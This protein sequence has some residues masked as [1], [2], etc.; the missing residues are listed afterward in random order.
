MLSKPKEIL[1]VWAVPC[2]LAFLASAGVMA[3]EMVAG[4]MLARYVGGS[5]YLWTSVIGVILGGMTVGNFIGG[6]L[7][8]RFDTRKTVPALFLL[9]A[10]VCFAIPFMNEWTILWSRWNVVNEVSSWPWR[11]F[12]HVFLV[13]FLPAVCLGLVSPVVAKRALEQ[14][15]ATGRTVGNVY[16]CGALGSIVGTFVTGFVLIDAVGTAGVVFGVATVLAAVGIALQPRFS[17]R[18]LAM[19]CPI[20]IGCAVGFTFYKA[21]PIQ[22]TWT[23][24]DG[25]RVVKEVPLEKV[26]YENESHYSFMKVIETPW[27]GDLVRCLYLD[28][29]V[30]AICVPA[31]P[32]KLIYDYERI[33]AS[34][35]LRF[36]R[37]QEDLRGLFL[38]G[39]GYVFPRFFQERWPRGTVQVDE[40]DPAV[41]T[42][43]FEA[44]LLDPEEV[45]ILEGSALAAG[46]ALA[47]AAGEQDPQKPNRIEI[48]HMDARIHVEDLLKLKRSGKDFKTFD[49]IYGD[50]F[51]DYGPPYHLTTKEFVEKV[52]DLLTPETGLYCQNVI[53]I[54]NSGRFLGASYNTLKAVFPYVY[55]FC[56]T[57]NGPNTRPNGRDTF[58]VIAGFRELDLE[59]LGE[60]EGELP[61]RGAKLT[62]EHIEILKSRSRGVILTDDYAPVENLLEEVVRRRAHQ[63]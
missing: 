12:K 61:F 8:D 6:R 16:A 32:T 33:Y 22:R 60:R 52:R 57:P 63:N 51:S 24:V 27:E 30:H 1:S 4:R 7:A 11:I 35:T 15:F 47:A 20:V 41:T 62:D 56:T 13:F 46:H 23:Q 36:G 10:L 40:I 45:V 25:K 54:F 2:G 39:G 26:L 21:P 19:A 48:Y 29:L 43:N 17:L 5:L 49:F 14:G 44:F 28:N 34:V 38:G 31:E 18:V 55:I 53:E 42:A 37:Q 9:A 59:N 50:A 3:I 58:I